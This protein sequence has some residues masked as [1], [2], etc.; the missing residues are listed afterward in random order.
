MS[1]YPC[2]SSKPISTLD[3]ML[4]ILLFS[5]FDANVLADT[6]EKFNK[7]VGRICL[8]VNSL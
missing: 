7:R 2:L 3:P 1:L 4:S 8:A 5:K 6:L